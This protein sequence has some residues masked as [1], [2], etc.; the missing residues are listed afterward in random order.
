[1]VHLDKLSPQLQEW[2]RILMLPPEQITGE[3][4]E[5]RRRLDKCESYT[6]FRVANE[7]RIAKKN[8]EADQRSAWLSAVRLDRKQRRK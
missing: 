4:A 5:K 1:M 8:A 7:A 3:D 6:K 2:I